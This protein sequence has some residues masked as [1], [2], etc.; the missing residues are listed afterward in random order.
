MKKV[1]YTI[2]ILL[3][4]SGC[5]NDD[6]VKEKKNIEI[7]KNLEPVFNDLNVLTDNNFESIIGIPLKDVEKYIVAVPYGVDNKII[8]AIKPIDGSNGKVS[9]AVNLYL[10]NINYRLNMNSSDND[11]QLLIQETLEEEY[12][13]YYV[14]I[15][16]ENVNE[17]FQLVKKFLD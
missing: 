5:N 11:E 16:G 14:Y 8:I 9:K 12:N 2:F 6:E 13:G 4:L 7:N 15:V 1:I 10:E 3:I 17:T